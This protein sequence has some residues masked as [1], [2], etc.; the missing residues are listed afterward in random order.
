[1]AIKITK[2]LKELK[3]KKNHAAGYLLG[4][5]KKLDLPDEG[6]KELK[7]TVASYFK[8]NRVELLQIGHIVAAHGLTTAKEMKGF[9]KEKNIGLDGVTISYLIKV[10]KIAKGDEQAVKPKKAVID[11]I[12]KFFL[13]GPSKKAVASNA[14]DNKTP[15]FASRAVLTV[16]GGDPKFLKALMSVAKTAGYSCELKST[17]AKA[18]P[19][20]NSEKVKAKDEKKSKTG[21]SSSKKKDK[22]KDK[23][24]K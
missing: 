14:K 7:N 1:M 20:K 3:K 19:A 21:K 11:G 16:T 12:T 24:K 10:S 9:I 17:E 8:E 18:K 6:L 13:D 4:L 15:A 5:K 2:V 23:K 22:K